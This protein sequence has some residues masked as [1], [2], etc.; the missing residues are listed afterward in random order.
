MDI[1]FI[2]GGILLWVVVV[3]MVKGLAKLEKPKGE[4]A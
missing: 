3:L 4:R 2:V 1:A